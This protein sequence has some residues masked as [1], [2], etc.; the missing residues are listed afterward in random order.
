MK[1]TALAIFVGIIAPPGWAAGWRFTVPED[2]APA[3]GAGVFHHVESAGRKNI[4]V[5]HGVV[6]VI[7]EDNRSGA[8]QVYVAF[9][10]SRDAPFSD[11]YP[12]SNGAS[13]YEPVI[14]GLN[15]G[16]FLMAW[17]QDG[18]VSARAGDARGLDPAYSL[19]RDGASQASLAV[20]GIQQIYAVWSQVVKRHA[21]I[22]LAMIAPQRA[23]GLVRVGEPKDVD[24]DPPS[25]DQ[26]YPSIVVNRS[27]V[28]VAWEDRR[29]GHTVLYYS[30]AKDG[31]HFGTPMMLN[32]LPPR[33]TTVYGRGTGVARVVLARYDANGVA[34]V[35]LDKR[36]FIEAYDVYA[37]LS[38]DGGAHFGPNQKV[39][40]DFA[41]G[42]AQWHAAIAGDRAG[43]VVA[44]WDDARDGT[45]DIWLSWRDGD[46]WS[47]DETVPSASGP[48]W[49]RSPA[50]ALDEKGNLHLVWVDRQDENGPTRIRYL[51][52]RPKGGEHSRGEIP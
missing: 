17:E 42:A 19:A 12:V 11:A 15:D 30:H 5:S 37:G 43:R 3:G 34:A 18:G 24:P 26:L 49:Q 40:D 48:G 10:P 33:R 13:A 46:G 6:A 44:V 50:L 35:W 28:T 29:R 23:V 47:V 7:W 21:R 52:G 38:D 27:G 32:E 41:T 14:V 9:K 51:F 45:S 16:R 8:P 39:Q 25:A 22:R 20:S 2:V 1:R 31:A 36:N 4:A